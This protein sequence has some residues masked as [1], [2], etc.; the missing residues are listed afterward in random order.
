M[1]ANLTYRTI[2]LDETEEQVASGPQRM[3]SFHAANLHATDARY[4]HFYDALI[5]DVTV[6][7]TVPKLTYAIPAGQQRT[8][9][10]PGGVRFNT[11][12][13]AACTTGITGA[14]AP[15]ANECVLNVIYQP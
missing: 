12:I 4:V 3:F 10:I 14:G 9:D 15:G 13:A 5:A 6:G 7:T 11:G 8:P 2:D 1:D